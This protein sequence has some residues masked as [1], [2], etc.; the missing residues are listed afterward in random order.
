MGRLPFNLLGW[1]S[2]V[3]D[4]AQKKKSPATHY[5]SFLPHPSER[6]RLRERGGDLAGNHGRPSC[7]PERKAWLTRWHRL[8][9][10]WSPGCAY[11]AGSRSGTTCGATSSSTRRITRGARRQRQSSARGRQRSARLSPRRRRPSRRGTVGLRDS[12][13]L[14]LCTAANHHQL[15][16]QPFLLF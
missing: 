5:Y 13:E 12:D 15:G 7:A 3:T 2:C 16:N 9:I 8:S 14:Q 1:M 6:A 10:R 4:T 11:R